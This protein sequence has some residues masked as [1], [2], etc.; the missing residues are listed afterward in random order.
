MNWFVGFALSKD[1][2]GTTFEYLERTKMVENSLWQYPRNKWKQLA[3]DIQILRIK[4]ECEWDYGKANKP[5]LQETNYKD[6]QSFFEN[7]IANE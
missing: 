2:E 4:V 5:V 3:Y 7:Y 1:N 6:I